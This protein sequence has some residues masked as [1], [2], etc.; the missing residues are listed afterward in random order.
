MYALAPLSQFNQESAL[1]KIPAVLTS[2]IDG[3]NNW[4]F[5][6]GEKNPF[7]YVRSRKN[8]GSKSVL[9]IGTVTN[10]I[11]IFE[12][13]NVLDLKVTDLKP[14]EA[15][16]GIG[17]Q[18]T[19]N[20]HSVS[21]QMQLN[22]KYLNDG[23]A[24]RDLNRMFSGVDPRALKDILNLLNREDEPYKATPLYTIEENRKTVLIALQPKPTDK[25]RTWVKMDLPKGYEFSA[26]TSGIEKTIKLSDIAALLGTDESLQGSYQTFLHKLNT[27]DAKWFDARNIIYDKEKGEVSFKQSRLSI[28]ADKEAKTICTLNVSFVDD[29]KMRPEA[30]DIND[31]FTPNTLNFMD[32]LQGDKRLEELYSGALSLTK[33]LVTDNT[34]LAGVP[35]YITYFGRDTL[36]TMLFL[37]NH[38]TPKMQEHFLQQVISRASAFGECA[39]EV[40]TRYD[41]SDER[42]YDYRMADSDFIFGTSILRYMDSKKSNHL[43][44]KKFMAKK[45]PRNRFRSANGEVMARNLNYVLHLMEEKNLLGIKREKDP[46]SGNWR[47]A[48]NSLGRGKYPYDLNCVWPQKIIY[49][50]EKVVADDEL[51]ELLLSFDTDA[52]SPLVQILKNPKKLNE[53]KGKW[54]QNKEKF[55]MELSVKEW[56]QQLKNYYEHDK[57]D[58]KRNDMLRKMPIGTDS[59]GNTLHAYDFIYENK[60]PAKLPNGDK[61]PEKFITYSMALDGKGNPTDIIH[62]DL[63][64]EPLFYDEAFYESQH[65][66]KAHYRN[67]F[68]SYIL[69]ISLGGLGVYN[70]SNDYIGFVVANPMLADKDGYELVL[71]PSE[72]A[73]GISPESLSPW[74][75]LNP[76]SY[77]G[78]GAV[79]SFQKDFYTIARAKL[80]M[81]LSS[82]EFRELY[83]KEEQIR[84]EIFTVEQV[85]NDFDLKYKSEI[86]GL[87]INPCQLW[88][89]AI[90]S[91]IKNQ[92]QSQTS[93][94]SGSRFFPDSLDNTIHSHLDNQTF[95]Q[96]V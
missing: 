86:E 21:G 51:S 23:R 52:S 25:E 62:S 31:I 55:K 35:N 37:F 10:Y 26:E 40:D 38:F 13:E 53:L 41:K 11:S 79:W 89:T 16:D 14:L 75:L 50:L 88:N 67:V 57:E 47:D 27:K 8:D 17:A 44:L 72:E 91:V 68:Y 15:R 77:H 9:E 48:L 78:M 76:D 65:F 64:I 96:S 95:A 66:D 42:H 54:N 7:T 60:I 2:N 85:L 45:D 56:R 83:S 73:N 29:F 81:D 43:E 94:I 22:L 46:S 69:P 4:Y 19:V 70:R 92:V 63:S 18:V 87:S 33:M 90:I 34:V 30:V 39:H 71:T 32:K 28:S 80:G 82:A 59:N 93:D 49:Y 61:F 3:K 6:S 84:P 24:F 1:D 20:A 5:L 74:Q 36:Y 12:F 58:K